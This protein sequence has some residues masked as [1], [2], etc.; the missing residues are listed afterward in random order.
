MTKP[1]FSILIPTRD[2]PDTFQHTLKT[3]ITQPGDDYE[4]V[5]MDNCSSPR[6]REIVNEYNSDKINYIRSDSILPMAENW[7]KGLA[8]CRGD[9]VTILGDDDAFLPS[10]LNLV[11]NMLNQTNAK[12]MSWALHTYWWPDTIVDWNRNRLY[13]DFGDNAT[14]MHKRNNLIAFY[15]NQI[16]FGSLP[17]IYNS[18]IH[19][20]CIE[21]VRQRFGCYFPIPHIPDVLSGVVNLTLDGDWVHSN[22]PLAMRG[23]SGKSNGTAYW[24]RSLG[25]KQ[26]EQYLLEEKVK[27]ENIVHRDL[28]AS[29]NL[30][31]LLADCKLKCKELFFPEDNEL[32]VDIG[33]VISNIIANLNAEPEAYVEN[34]A[35]AQALA[36]KHNLVI[37]PKIIPPHQ[38]VNRRAISGPLKNGEITTG[39]AVNCD[40]AGIFDIFAASRL[41][42]SL[43]PQ[44]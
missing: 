28:I 33:M 2:R 11:R 3:V 17:M 31:I 4:I 39:I 41:A 12:M 29:P 6:T 44:I 18:F 22:R 26:R 9:F 23:N 43:M 21:Q 7:E 34:L 30:Q 24:A 25:A 13:L 5:V 20:S 40:L 35:D 16:S 15:R 36:K 14:N 8:E 38:P 37:D 1:R 10:S 42:D 19:K 32:S 27:L